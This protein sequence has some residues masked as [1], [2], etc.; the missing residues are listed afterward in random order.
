MN[1]DGGQRRIPD[2]TLEQCL[3]G[4]LP[5]K[6]MGETKR[7]LDEDEESR[8]RLEAMERSNREILG[9]SVSILSLA[10]LPSS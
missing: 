1:P 7:I 9:G 4:E 3:V 6:E 8:A 10:I 2:I 5:E